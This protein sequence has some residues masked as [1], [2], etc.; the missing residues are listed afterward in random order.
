MS[1]LWFVVC[2]SSVKFLTLHLLGFLILGCSKE[3]SVRER[4]N[5]MLHVTTHYY[6]GHANTYYLYAA[7]GRPLCLT[8]KTTA[9]QT[10]DEILCQSPVSL[11]V[12]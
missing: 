2:L 3:S 7:A 8:G 11:K 9:G 12:G 1:P 5:D 10:G 6:L 4:H